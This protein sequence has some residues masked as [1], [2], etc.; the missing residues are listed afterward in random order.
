[1]HHFGIELPRYRLIPS[2]FQRAVINAQMFSP[3]EAVEGG[4]LD[5]IVPAEQLMEKA[6]QEAQRLAGLNMVAHKAT[7]LKTRAG[8]LKVLDDAIEKDFTEQAAV[9]K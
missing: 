2:Y 7:K 4:L 6:M 8:I 3:A 9:L 1:M 5:K